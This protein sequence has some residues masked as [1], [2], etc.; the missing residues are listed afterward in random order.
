MVIIEYLDKLPEEER[1]KI[2]KI[3]TKMRIDYRELLETLF[4]FDVDDEI[5]A[6]RIHSASDLMSIFRL[7]IQGEELD[8]IGES[9]FQS[10]D[11]PVIEILASLG[12]KDIGRD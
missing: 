6:E 4:V 1:L 5:V 3:I 2:G 12:I 8:M 7:Y 10:D 11:E 9:V